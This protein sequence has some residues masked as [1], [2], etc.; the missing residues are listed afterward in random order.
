MS[1]N[2]ETFKK[3]CEDNKLNLL[4]N[5]EEIKINREVKIKGLCITKDCNN[6]FN[7]SFRQLVKVCGYCYECAVEN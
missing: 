2:N 5:Y 4:D 7:K 6:E 3:Y 1:Y